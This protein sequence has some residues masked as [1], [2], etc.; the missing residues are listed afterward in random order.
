MPNKKI[1][2]KW[3]TTKR[4]GDT[5]P[6]KKIDKTMPPPQQDIPSFR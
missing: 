3:K 6:R 1:G 2:D 4:R 5:A